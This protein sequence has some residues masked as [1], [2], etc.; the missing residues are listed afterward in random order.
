MSLIKNELQQQLVEVS[1]NYLRWSCGAREYQSAKRAAEQRLNVF[2]ITAA[3]EKGARAAGNMRNAHQQTEWLKMLLEISQE[4]D[5]A[6]TF[7]LS[8]ITLHR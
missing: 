6:E 7:L 1:K 5:L 2:E 4:P 8:P 3:Q